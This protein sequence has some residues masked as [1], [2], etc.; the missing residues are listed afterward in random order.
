MLTL[1]CP[2]SPDW[3]LVVLDDFDSFLQDHAAA[4][5]KAAGMAMSML[6][7]YPD[8]P[9]LVKAMLDLAIEEMTHFR[10]VVRLM[11]RRDIVLAKDTK[12]PYVNQLRNA[13]RTGKDPYLLDRLLVAGIVEARGCERFGLIAAALADLELQQFYQRITASEAKH[14]TLFVELAQQYFPS[15][16]IEQ[17]LGE[18]LTIEGEIV[19]KLPLRAALH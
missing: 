8:K 10:E 5:K 19:A 6:S 9:A 1:A 15:Q 17:R 13:I 2:T 11:Q 7:H 12:D 3:A 16:E 18:L 4:E 14:Q